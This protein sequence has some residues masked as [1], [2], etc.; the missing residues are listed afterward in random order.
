M[1]FLTLGHSLCISDTTIS[2]MVVETVDKDIIN[3]AMLKHSVSHPPLHVVDPSF[4]L[5]NISIG[6]L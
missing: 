5:V 2:I 3:N 1:I 4:P 6:C